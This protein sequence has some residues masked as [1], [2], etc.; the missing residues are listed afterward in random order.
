MNPTLI[1]MGTILPKGGIQN[2]KFNNEVIFLVISIAEMEGG[3]IKIKIA[4]FYL[5]LIFGMYPKID[6]DD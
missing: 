3:E 2:L 5:Y 6:M 4:R 1:F